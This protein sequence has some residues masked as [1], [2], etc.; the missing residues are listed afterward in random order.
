MAIS[1]VQALLN[2]KWYTLTY[3]SS[4]GKYET[5]ITAPGASGTYPL[6]I[7]ATNSAGKQEKTV[8][9]TVRTELIPPTATITSPAAGGWYTNARQP[10]TFQLRDNDGGSGVNLSTLRFIIDGQ[11]LTSTSPG[12]V[13]T[14]AGNGYDCTYTPPSNLADGSHTATVSVNDN[15]GN[16]GAAV[17]RS[18]NIDTVNPSLVVTS[19]AIGLITNNPTLTISG[20]AS[21]AGAGIAT[22]K[23]NGTNVPVNNGA[24]SYA[25]T[26]AEGTNNYTIVATDTVGHT[27]TITRSV[28]LDTVP[29]EFVSVHIE[30]VLN[31]KPMGFAYDVTVV[32][33][34][35]VV[36]PK[37]KEIVTGTLNGNPIT[38]TESPAL[39]WKSRVTRQM[40]DIYTFV[41]VGSDEAGNSTTYEITFPCG[42][43]SKWN[44]EAIEFLNYWDL[45]RIERNTEYIY[46]WLVEYGYGVDDFVTKYDWN[47]YDIPHRHD[48]DRIRHNIDA[49]QDCFAKLPEWRTILYNTTVN[50]SQ[51]NA[52]EWD[53]HLLDLWM[54]QLIETIEKS[55]RCGEIISGDVWWGGQT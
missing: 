37:S 7:R 34:P 14:A 43:E 23:V 52:F 29:P 2:G 48:I 41:L 4:T 27:T 49:L 25:V 3:N 9:I 5:N 28:L 47:E 42:M 15:E 1:S 51:M 17:S 30:P 36:S 20:T 10:V 6:T 21:D 45:N 55:L 38:F 46:Q 18:W 39:T 32:L 19:P 54:I 26:M 22:V 8:D 44:W 33:A 13:C 40:S 31:V 16:T 24:F 12:M 11:T 53:L 50:Y 35:S